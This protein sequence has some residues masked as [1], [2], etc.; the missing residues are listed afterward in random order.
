MDVFDADS[1]LRRLM[2]DRELA[3]T[4]LMGFINNGPALL[5]HLR[6]RLDDSDAPGLRTEAHTL[7]GA[8]ATVAAEALHLAALAIE[9][10]SMAGHLDSCR[11]LLDGVNSEFERFKTSVKRDGW[12][13]GG[14]DNTEIDE[15][16][17]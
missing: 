9:T 15:D 3:G 5:K 8:A 1:L 4:L 12:V 2:D 14:S 11:G 13:S 17:Q 6:E 7:S 16:G 10:E